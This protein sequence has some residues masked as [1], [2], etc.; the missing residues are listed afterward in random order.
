MFRF[1]PTA[2]RLLVSVCLIACGNAHAATKFVNYEDF[3]A[4]GD[5]K[6]DDFE[7]LEKAHEYANKHGLLVKVKDGASYYIGGADRTISIRT[8]TDFGKA[9]F[10]IDDTK[11][12]NHKADVF[13]VGSD[14]KPIKLK[15]IDSLS[16]GQTR[17]NANLPGP[18]VVT[19][20]DT[21]I[22]RFIRRGLNQNNGSPQTDAFLVDERGN[23][24]PNTPIIWDFKKLTNL[25]A[26]PVDESTLILRG[27]IFTTI[28]NSTESTAY[29][30]RGIAI[31]RSNV[32]VED[33]QHLITGE[34]KDGPPYGGFI[35]VTDCANVVVKNT[36]LTGHKTY[37]KIGSAGKRVPMGSYDISLSR[38]LNIALVNVTQANDIM[39]RSR[40]GIIGTNFCKN[41]LYD[42]CKLSRFDAHQG[43]TNASIRNSTIGHMGVLLTGFGNFLI[44]NSTVQSRRFIGLR[45][46]Y[47]STWKGDITIRNCRFV[48]QNGGT[49]L[50]G[51]N[52]GQHDFGYTC[53][54]PDRLLI[55]GLSIDDGKPSKSGKG[56]VI[57][58]NFNPK[59][60]N[61]DYKQK[62]PYVITREVILKNITTT[63][64]K[65]LR[66]SDNKFMFKD[67]NVQGLE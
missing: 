61:G 52:D 6:T 41:L 8:S 49:I 39:D 17:I 29:H 57:F 12:E 15:G 22:R 9:R 65:P 36:I 43:V 63:S 58:N 7:A 50:D 51:S 19:A 3:G 21:S 27:G 2:L 42:G 23:V 20:T 30:A 54:M 4:K 56:P 53:Y 59:F 24:N 55:D 66:L 48:P 33:L 31:R 45:P 1:T 62:F 67:V 37:Y 26:M 14:L 46:D 5:G 18:C 25:V 34:G 11:L 47:G 16:V 10:I 35:K 38:A 40:W 44:E 13:R 64:G 60:S 28:A 32:V